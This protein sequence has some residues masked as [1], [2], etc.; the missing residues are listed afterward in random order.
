MG[1][2]DTQADQVYV[3]VTKARGGL[4]ADLALSTLAALFVLGLNPTS[5]LKVLEKCPE[6]YHV[7]G[8]QVQQRIG[9]LRRLGLV[10]GEIMIFA[11]CMLCQ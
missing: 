10:E 8:S 6:L 1:F 2:T 4:A 7:K 5:V 3:T 9:N 11:R